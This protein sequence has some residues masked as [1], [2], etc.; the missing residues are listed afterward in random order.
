M[1]YFI[2]LNGKT[3]PEKEACISIRDRGFLY[4]DGIFETIRAYNGYTFR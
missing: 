4:G 3:V 1:N 2:Y